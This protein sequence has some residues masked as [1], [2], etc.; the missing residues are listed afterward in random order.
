MAGE[1]MVESGNGKRRKTR[2]ICDFNAERN[3][4][5]FDN[6]NG[7]TAA[8]RL[9]VRPAQRAKDGLN[10]ARVRMEILR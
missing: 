10:V 3:D 8:H 2:E 1:L 4:G 6:L 9:M 7:Q 5:F